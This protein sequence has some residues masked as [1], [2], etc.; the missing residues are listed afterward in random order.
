M[1]LS[2]LYDFEAFESFPDTLEFRERLEG[3]EEALP[4]FICP[5]G[6]NGPAMISGALS[7]VWYPCTVAFRYNLRL[8]VADLLSLFDKGFGWALKS[9]LC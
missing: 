7:R 4:A 5:C 9:Y 8:G 6:G 3:F 2:D 1:A